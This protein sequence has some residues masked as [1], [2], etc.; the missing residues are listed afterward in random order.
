MEE[1]GLI[2]AQFN[3]HFAQASLGQ[4]VHFCLVEKLDK[5]L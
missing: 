2:P 1:I 3:Q 5:R 4:L